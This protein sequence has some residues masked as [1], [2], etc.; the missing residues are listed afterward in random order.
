MAAFFRS[1]NVMLV[2]TLVLFTQSSLRQSLTVKFKAL[3][4]GGSQVAVREL[5]FVLK[6]KFEIGPGAT[7]QTSSQIRG[8][9][10]SVGQFPF[11]CFCASTMKS[12]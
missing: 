9:Q 12:I 1:L 7:K 4:L 11:I 8:D 2:V 3:P 5:E 6:I 10:C